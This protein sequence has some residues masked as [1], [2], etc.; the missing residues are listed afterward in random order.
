MS[1]NAISSYRGNRHRPPARPPARYR[2]DRLQYTA[3][4][5]SAQC[6]QNFWELCRIVLNIPY[7]SCK[8]RIDTS[9]ISRKFGLGILKSPNIGKTAVQSIR[10]CFSMFVDFC[11]S[12][13]MITYLFKFQLHRFDLPRVLVFFL[14]TFENGH[15]REYSVVLVD[16][17]VLLRTCWIIPYFKSV[18]S[19]KAT[20]RATVGLASVLSALFTVCLTNANRWKPY[21]PKTECCW[22]AAAALAACA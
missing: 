4:L 7:Q 8:R 9:A 21:T 22:P 5:A 17:T 20:E 11:G 19:A 2:Q 1:M 15:K 12:K 10:C 6:N 3:P 13:W 18:F 14:T 16:I